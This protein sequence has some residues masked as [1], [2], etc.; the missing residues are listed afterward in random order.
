LTPLISNQ[1][2]DRVSTYHGYGIKIP[3][4]GGSI[5]HGYGDQNTMDRGQNTMGRGVNMP[6]VGGVKIPWVGGRYTMGMGLHIPLVGDPN[7]MGK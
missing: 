4:V 5:F 7:T 2:I 1:E 3:W 6:M